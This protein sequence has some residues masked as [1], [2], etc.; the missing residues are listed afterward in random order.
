MTRLTLNSMTIIEACLS[1]RWTPAPAPILLEPPVMQSA[2][3]FLHLQTLQLAQ[4]LL[5]IL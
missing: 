5:F 3:S 1:V 2:E 4:E